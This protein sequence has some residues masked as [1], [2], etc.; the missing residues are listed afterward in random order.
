M[1]E[2]EVYPNAP[3]AV[4]VAE[5]RHPA[6]AALSP[7]E[8][9]AIKAALAHIAPIART[10]NLVEIDMQSGQQTATKLTRFVSRDLHQSISFRPDAI[11][12]ESTEYLGWVRFL[13]MV[14]AATHARHD[15]APVDGLERVGLRYMDEVRVPVSGGS[16]V[17]SEWI[18]PELMGPVSLAGLVK[19]QVVGQQGVT[20]LASE[21]GITY[22]VRYGTGEGQVFTS[23]PNLRRRTEATGPF[24][25]VDV[26]GAWQPID[27]EIPEFSTD[28]IAHILERLHEPISVIFESLI[29]DKL[30]NEVLR[31]AG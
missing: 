3:I 26:D 24:F 17:W 8:W 2:H 15:T 20:T 10:E 6:T 12:V 29:T 28:T 7:A 21:P 30:R 18:S 16:T 11:V 25:L 14:T 13:E 9:N 4:V 31:I 27:Q 5:I 1:A 22:T 19:K 23:T